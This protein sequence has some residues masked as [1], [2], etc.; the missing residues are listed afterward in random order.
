MIYTYKKE[1]EL[2]QWKVRVQ[3]PNGISK[4]GRGELCTSFVEGE[5]DKA[6]ELDKILTSWVENG[7]EDCISAY[8]LK[9]KKRSKVGGGNYR[10]QYAKEVEAVFGD[11]AVKPEKKAEVT[12]PLPAGFAGKD[13][14]AGKGA[15]RS[16]SEA[17][18]AAAGRQRNGRH[19]ARQ[20]MESEAASQALRYPNP[21]LR[22][23]GRA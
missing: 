10:L 19:A 6:D 14:R 22:E 4:Y 13:R 2:T 21:V 5:F 18:K 7:K 3:I 11:T 16:E 1:G 12:P 23:I 20:G 8:C 15:G 9:F 17:G